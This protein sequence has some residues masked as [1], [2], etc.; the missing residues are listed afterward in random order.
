[1]AVRSPRFDA[2]YERSID[3]PEGFWGEA[4]RAIDWDVPPSACSTRRP[5]STAGSPTAQLNTATTR[6]T[7]TSRAGAATSR[8]SIYDSPVTGTK[9][10]LHLRRAA[11]RGRPPRRRAARPRRG[12]RRPRR[13][14]HAD[15]ARGG[16]RH[17]RLRPARRDALG[18]VRRLRRRT[19]SRS[20]STTRSPR[21]SSRRRAASRARASS[22]TSRCSTRRS[23]WPTHK[24]E[25][26]VILQRPQLAAELDPGRDLD[27]AEAVAARRARAVR[28]GARDRPAL[29]PLHLGHDRPAEGR[30]AR[31]RR[32]RRRARVE[33]A[34]TSTASQPGRGL[35]GG[36]RRRLGRRPLATSSTRRCWSA[37][38]RCCT[39]ASRSARPTRARSGA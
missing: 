29:H 37:A 17:A 32:P 2:V 36:L 4:A 24:P 10:T 7:A 33:H 30:G 8:R 3:D 9:R 5:R 12:R 18:R 39:R 26:C 28:A 25:H 27:W 22:P 21:S 15:G 6:S 1:M 35:L 23:S 34:A 19:S 16:L 13:P 11:R 14:L 38:R 20:A 31:Q